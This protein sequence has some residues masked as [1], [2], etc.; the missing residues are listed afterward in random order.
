MGNMLHDGQWSTMGNGSRQATLQD[1]QCFTMGNMLHDG[2]SFNT[3]QYFT[4]GN[5]SRCTIMLHD[6]QCFTMWTML[7]V[8]QYASRCGQCFQYFTTGQCFT[9]NNASRQANASRWAMLHGGPCFTIGNAS[10][11]AML[12]DTQCFTMGSASRWP[13]FTTGN[14]SRF[15]WL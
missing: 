12:H 4:M 7:H 15:I 11:H 3:G 8:G 14:T 13:H 10:R 1:G 9:M 5:A 2:Q 6:G